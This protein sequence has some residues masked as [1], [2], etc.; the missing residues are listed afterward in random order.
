MFLKVPAVL[1]GIRTQLKSPMRSGGAGRAAIASAT[2]FLKKL[3][4]S[5]AL[6]APEGA[7]TIDMEEGDRWERDKLCKAWGEVRDGWNLSSAVE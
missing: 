4:L 2:S 7:W 5:A 3:S 1:A 6:W